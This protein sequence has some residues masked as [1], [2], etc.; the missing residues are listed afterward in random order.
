MKPTKIE[1]VIFDW[2]G[3]TIDHGCFAPISAFIKAFQA[4]GVELTPSQARGPMG[5]HKRDHIRCLFQIDEIAA[6]WKAIHQN[7]WSESDV[8]HIYETFTPLQVDEA[9]N[10]TD[11]ISG[12]SE[13]VSQ[14]KARGI[15]IGATTGYP[16]IVLEPIL[17]VAEAQGYAPDFT[18]CA[19]EVPAGRPAPWMIYRNMEAL[20]IFPPGSV[21]KVGD[22]V[23]DIEA[24]LNAGT[25]TVGLTQTGSE[26]GLTVAEFDALNSDQQHKLLQTAETKLKNAGAH[27]VI[28][29]LKELPEIINQIES[30]EHENGR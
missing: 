30:G 28:P 18:M 12:V 22:T 19:D 8:E 9:Q 7:S 11:L 23:P 24:G 16:R 10:Y 13:T 25:W 17:K 27:F 14:L 21:V 5:L 6:Q 4:C 20:N 15:K 1:L 29:T 2:A 26:V 3:T